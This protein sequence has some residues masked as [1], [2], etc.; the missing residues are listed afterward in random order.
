MKLCSCYNQIL[1]QL[2]FFSGRIHAIERVLQN[3]LLILFCARYVVM[4][5]ASYV[6]I[7]LSLIGK[8][9]KF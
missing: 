5:I 2:Y 9:S 6:T 4:E 1:N 7:L 3:M 8:K